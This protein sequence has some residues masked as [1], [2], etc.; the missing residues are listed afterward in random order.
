MSFCACSSTI[1]SSTGLACMSTKGGRLVGLAFSRYWRSLNSAIRV[2]RSCVRHHTVRCGV[3]GRDGQDELSGNKMRE[4]SLIVPKPEAYRE[5][6]HKANQSIGNE[7][8]G[9]VQH[10][11][12]D[13]NQL[14][15]I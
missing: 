1:F 5:R 14:L 13:V 12:L 4:T 3:Q 6:Q 8:G 2:P 10:T 9:L 11:G 15:L 7:N